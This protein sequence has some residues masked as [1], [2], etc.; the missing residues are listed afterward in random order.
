MS[1]NPIQRIAD[2]EAQVA[3][4]TVTN[5]KLQSNGNGHLDLEKLIEKLIK[6]A[7]DRFGQTFREDYTGKLAGMIQPFIES[8]VRRCKEVEEKQMVLEAGF[9]KHEAAVTKSASSIATAFI[10]L[11][12]GSEK[13]FQAHRAQMQEDIKQVNGYALWFL[14]ELKKSGL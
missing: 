7:F 2:L 14:E 4:L 1:T 9:K 11:R 13:D 10:Q 5:E 12:E 3:S 6:Q 8:T